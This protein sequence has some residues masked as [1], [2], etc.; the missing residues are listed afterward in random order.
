MLMTENL[1]VMMLRQENMS[2]YFLHSSHQSTP[3]KHSCTYGIR[4]L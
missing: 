1:H 4:F 3:N 2:I